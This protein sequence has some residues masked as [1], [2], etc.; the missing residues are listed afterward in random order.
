MAGADGQTDGQTWGTWRVQGDGRTDTGSG[1]GCWQRAGMEKDGWTDRQENKEWGEIKKRDPGTRGWR[2]TDVRSNPEW[3]GG[4]QNGQTD[5]W[6]GGQADGRADGRTDGPYRRAQAQEGGGAKGQQQQEGDGDGDGDAGD[7]SC[8]TPAGPRGAQGGRG[9]S[10]HGS[11]PPPAPPGPFMA[12]LAPAP[13]AS[14]RSPTPRHGGTHPVTE[15]H[16]PSGQLAGG[17]GTGHA[18]SRHTT[19]HVALTDMCVPPPTTPVLQPCTTRLHTRGHTPPPLTPGSPLKCPPPP[20]E[21]PPR[22][23]GN[24][25]IRGEPPPPGP[26]AHPTA[27]MVPPRDARSAQPPTL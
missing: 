10:G 11:V 23:W 21:K 19:P 5:R 7:S 9:G 6:T 16:A 2:R 18:P 22:R 3:S 20:Q 27:S 12:P 26:S 8:E 4:W 15:G 1:D 25:D 13:R 24:P 14:S 17:R